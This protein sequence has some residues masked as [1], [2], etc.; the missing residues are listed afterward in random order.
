[1]IEAAIARWRAAGLLDAET[2][3]RILR[4]ETARGERPGRFRWPVILA[5]VAGGLMLSAG[6]LLFVAAHWD[7]L[8]PGGRVALLVGGLVAC[9]GAGV[10]SAERFPAL[11]VTLHAVGTA[12][13]GATVF[14]L[15]QTYHLHD[16]WSEGFL[17]W[18]LGGWTGWLLLRQW[19]QVLYAAVLTPAWIVAEWTVRAERFGTVV[20]AAPMAGLLYLALVYLHA[21]R[22]GGMSAEAWR[23]ALAGIGAVAL[24]P[25]AIGLRLVLGDL[26]PILTW[27]APGGFRSLSWGLFLGL[28]ALLAIALRGRHLVGPGVA[29]AWVLAGVLLPKDAGAWSFL[30]G[31]LGAIGVAASGVA[32]GSRL[33]I[34]L[35]L[36][37]FALTVL[38]F[39]FSSVL[40][41]LG[42]S[43]S[44]LVGGVLFLGIG[45]G[46]ERVRRRLVARVTERGS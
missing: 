11:A 8:A 22:P 2:A 34:N 44:L 36:G 21:S 41:R 29:L 4:Y 26:G 20:P 28:P 9:H 25:L 10:L 12:A 17:L 27:A 3:E 18:A 30:W 33:P 5:L 19:P 32:A 6:A 45:W 31:G 14:L 38:L 1:M 23:T 46:V 7:T 24:I 43:A 39:Y 40:D 16:R 15:G 13:L 35:G 42:R 37:A